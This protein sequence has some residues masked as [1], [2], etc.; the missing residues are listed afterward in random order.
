[1]AGIAWRGRRACQCVIDATAE[2]EARSK[3]SL[4]RRIYQA[5]YSFAAASAGTHGGGGALDTVSLTN[6]L[7]LTGRTIGFWP[8]NRYRSQGFSMAHAHWVLF[9]CPHAPAG[10]RYQESELR[11]GRN[12][13]AG[14]G[15]DTFPRPARVQTFRQYMAGRYAAAS[16]GGGGQASLLIMG[17][18][19]EPISTVSL[20]WVNYA[21]RTGKFSRHIYWLQVWLRKA[22]YYHA[23]LDGKPGKVTQAA[24]DN[25]RRKALGYTAAQSKG[26]TGLGT[27][28]R[29]RDSANSSLKLRTGK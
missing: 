14:R 20:W 18:K 15:R 7:T 11:A 21:L 22:G 29:L 1:M 16:G 24:L 27:L 3:Y 4:L 26:P 2:F 9:G 25:Y 8:S 6:S 23:V 5:C 10:L 19:Y 28:Q 13:L 12:G 17:K